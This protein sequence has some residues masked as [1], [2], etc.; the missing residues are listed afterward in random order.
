MAE[1]TKADQAAGTHLS[2]PAIV[3][4][5]D[6]SKEINLSKPQFSLM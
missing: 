6:L 5:G 1:D 4:H 3:L 2:I